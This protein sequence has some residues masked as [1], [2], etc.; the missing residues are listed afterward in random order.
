MLLASVEHAAT[1]VSVLV[2]AVCR[3]KRAIFFFY[4]AQFKKKPIIY[5]VV[6]SVFTNFQHTK[7]YSFQNLSLTFGSFLKYS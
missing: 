7:L 1:A 2:L 6:L 3:L 5:C 4:T